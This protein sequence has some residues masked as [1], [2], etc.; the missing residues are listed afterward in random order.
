MKNL[1]I[2][3]LII[4]SVTCFNSHADDRNYAAN[5]ISAE[6]LKNANVVKRFEEVK[7]EIINIGKAKLYHTVA[8]TVLNEKGDKYVQYQQEYDKL[9]SIESI[10]G[11]LFDENGKKI[12][13]L[14][15]NDIQD[16]S[17]TSEASLADDNRVKQFNF[18]YKVYPYT[19]EYE[20]EIKYNY[21]LFYP[22]WVPQEDEF[23]SVEY[24]KVSISC[25]SD[26][27]FRYKTFNYPAQ[28]VITDEKNNKVYSWEV[29]N[30]PA[31]EEE[32]ASPYWFEITPVVSLAP[33]QFQVENYQ[34]NMSTWQDFGKFVYALK[35]GRDQ[36][37][38]NIK[39]VIHNITDGIA[40]TRKKIEVLYDFFQK[41]TRYISIQLGIGGWQPFDAKYV[42]SNRYGDCKALSN[43]MYSLLK[44]AGIKSFY[45]L[46]KAGVNSR[47]FMSDFPS[48]QFNHVI[49]CVPVQ[50]D[51]V[52][53]ECTSQTLPAGYLSSFTSDRNVLLVD[54]N[55]GTLIR[56]PRYTLNQNLQVRKTVASIDSEGNLVADI[57]TDY[58]ALQ[59]DNLH[60][61][62]NGLSKDKVM[63]YLKNEIDLP[64][65]DVVKFDYKEMKSAL[66]VIKETL[67]VTANN[68]A[69]VSGSRLFVVPNLLSRSHNKLIAND[70]RKFDVQLN[71][72]YKDIDSVEIKIPSGYQPEAMPPAMKI[73]TKFGRY[74]S[75]VQVLADKIIY[76]RSMEQFRG[77][78]PATAYN[79]LVKF[80]EQIYKSDRSRVV[81]IKK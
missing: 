72:E 40:D 73:E 26:I 29:K 3:L 18:Y 42:A 49:L 61:L 19:V 74:S 69:Q 66:P 8:I 41:N 56:T 25:P 54:E 67:S 62:I 38:D 7:F 5:K 59:Q 55:G 48:S 10:E 47:F 4:F 81:L 70:T 77:R 14:K 75:S 13:T 2:L 28:P 9:H 20:T 32:F 15:K 22:I 58:R 31:I 24:S 50:K 63:E 68:Y 1:N 11:R 64:N 60:G 51:T 39:N 30:L 65:Y 45:T 57:I 17:G 36:L 37:P 53:L 34:G 21:T 23:Y 52:W 80:Y 43:Y 71:T 79:E 12:K 16:L 46:V 6:L 44:E 76:Y 27:K 33:V 35:D 78:F